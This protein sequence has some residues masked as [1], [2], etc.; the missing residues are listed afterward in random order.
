MDSG[1]RTTLLCKWS[2]KRR[3]E[4]HTL[5]VYIVIDA[6]KSPQGINACALK[7]HLAHVMIPAFIPRFIPASVM[8]P[9]RLWS[10][11]PGNDI[12]EVKEKFWS[13]NYFISLVLSLCKMGR[14]AVGFIFRTVFGPTS[15]SNFSSSSDARLRAFTNER[16]FTK[17]SYIS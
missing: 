8:T 13:V 16:V 12:S 3:V 9:I 7:V 1:N 10:I 14:W 5:G 6:A 17:I 4:Q 15:P 11:Y 2:A